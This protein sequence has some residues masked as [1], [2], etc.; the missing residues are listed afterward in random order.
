M[1][2]KARDYI[3]GNPFKLIKGETD[4]TLRPIVSNADSSDNLTYILLIVISLPV[5]KFPVNKL[6]LCNAKNTYIEL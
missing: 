1:L 4:K 2:C 6:N 5:F 3:P